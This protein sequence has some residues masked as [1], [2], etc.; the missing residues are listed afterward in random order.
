MEKKVDLTEGDIL[1]TL[2]KLAIPI[3]GT[4]FIQMA[5]SLTDM[6]WVGQTGSDSVA[7]VG[8]AGFFIWFAFSLILL[9]KVGAEVL[10]AQSL[11][12]K[13][14]KNARTFAISAIQLTIFFAIVYGVGV[15]LFRRNLIAFFRLGQ[16]NVIDMAVTYLGIVSMGL[17]F[18]FVNPVMTGIFNGA[19]LSKIPFQINLVGL[20]T[21]MILD[22]LLIFGV[23]PFPVMGV[24][25]AAVA[26]VFSQFLV[27]MIFLSVMG[28][29]EEIYFK[30]NIL[31][32]PSLHHFRKIIRLGLPVA[33]QNGFFAMIA[34]G[35]ARIIA[36]YGP[37]A[38]A[39][40][41][42]GS[43]IESISWM[44][45]SGFSTALSAFV[46]QNYGAKQYE[47]ILKGYRAGLFAISI[48]GVLA[49][50]L[51][52]GFAEPLFSIFIHES[53]TIRMGGDYLVI[54]GVSQIFMTLEIT[55]QGAFN[56]LGRTMIPSYV[57]IL[58]NALRIPAA[59]FLSTYTL[60]QLNG[61]WWAITISS[62]FKG[63]VLLFFF[64][65]LVIRP[66]HKT[67]QIR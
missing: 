66:Y 61:V 11:G 25:G 17:I 58:F 2:T 24:F 45:A 48:I 28:K 7:A 13:D 57:G 65:L 9:S 59:Y 29:R 37:E 4:S 5:Y 23:G 40:Q 20:V 51:L 41:K 1:K 38:I 60:L 39:V 6:F 14:E 50:I 30:L 26:T 21:N 62:V 3:M 10:V 22:P 44:T 33:M 15:F 18:T 64:Y 32:R 16:Q 8:T 53:D 63:T 34:M 12:K 19:G 55:S 52:M 47:R 46:G 54:L 67:G 35:I 43:Q 49:T 27:T 56:G 36:V 31:I 42:I